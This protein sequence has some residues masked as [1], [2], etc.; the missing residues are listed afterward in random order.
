MKFIPTSLVCAKPKDKLFPPALLLVKL[1]VI[2]F[3]YN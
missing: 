1:V 2:L 3:A